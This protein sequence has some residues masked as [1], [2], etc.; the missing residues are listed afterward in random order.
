MDGTKSMF[1]KP[2]STASPLGPAVTAPKP[3]FAPSTSTQ[4]NTPSASAQFNT[5]SA[6]AQFQSPLHVSGP[7]GQSIT[8]PVI[9]SP[10]TNG[11][12]R[13][14]GPASQAGG[15]DP[16]GQ[17][18]PSYMSQSVRVAPTRPRLDAREAA[19]KLANM[20]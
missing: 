14:G 13:S 17:A 2:P 5:P 15:F 20:F 4:F 10:L 3:A 11:L 16:L 18:R 9:D 6:S 1:V 19:S 8:A 12:N 7:L